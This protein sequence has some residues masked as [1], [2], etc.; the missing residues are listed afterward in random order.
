MEQLALHGGT[1]VRT[2][3]YPS[4]PVFGEPEERRLLAV[5]RSGKWGRLDGDEVAEFERRFAAFQGA[6]FGLASVNGTTTLRIALLAA[7]IEAGDEVIVPPYTFIATAEAV[8][9]V[10]AVP[11]FVDIEP[12]TYNLDARRIAEAV[13]DRTRAIIPVHLGGLCADMDAI[14]AVARAHGLVVI[15]DA[16]HAHGARYNDRG[17]GSIGQM[18]SFSFQASKNLTAGEGGI[19]LTNDETLHAACHSIHNCGRA[20]KGGQWYGHHSLGANYRMT[21]FQAA[22]L[23]TQLDRLGDQTA[24][25][26]DNGRYLAERLAEVPGVAPQGERGYAT[27]HGYH[28]FL[29]RYDEAAWDLPRDA[30]TR[31]ARAEGVPL[32]PGY[33]RPLYRQ[34]IFLERRFGPYTG[35]RQSRPDVDFAAFAERCP[36][37]EHV[38]AGEGTWLTQNV[39]LAER[40]DMDDVAE[41]VAKVYRLR[42]ALRRDAA[43]STAA[44]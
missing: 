28:L 39:L 24:R 12:D 36:V 6:G 32:W 33:K 25:R 9:E 37:A 15:E 31:A 44:G 10:N 11:V 20:P 2:D 26:N 43:R 42:D 1:P 5:L 34:P 22:V 16:A 7:G 35:Y 41:A 4:W 27:T 17:A 8:I 23:N 13:T 29:I 40:R 19:I 3:P 14:L 21:E 30:F 38:T 18:G